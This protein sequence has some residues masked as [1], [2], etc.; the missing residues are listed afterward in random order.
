M[1]VDMRSNATDELLKLQARLLELVKEAVADENARWKSDKM[2]VE[3]RLIGDRPAGIVA[4]DS[5]IVLAT[6]RAG[7]A[8]TRGPRATF[9]GS[10][11]PFHNAM[12]LGIP[13]L[14]LCRATGGAA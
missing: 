2:T 7:S 9:A 11:T 1:A 8:V 10:S 13:G 5:P 4:M 14:N 3:A 12:S 6:Q